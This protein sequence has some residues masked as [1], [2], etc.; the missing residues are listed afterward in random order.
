[1]SKVSWSDFDAVLFDLDGVITATASIHAAAWKAA[2]DEFLEARGGDHEPFDIET[3]YRAHV[4]GRPRYEGVAAFLESRGIDL[5]RGLPS[6]RPGH[7]TIC[8]LGNLKNDAFER[9][10]AERGADVYEGSIALLDH[11]D[12]IGMPYAVVSASKNAVPIL[13]SVGHLPRFRAV[14]DGLVAAELGL[15]GKP[16][17]DPFLEGARRVG[18]EPDRAVVVED[19]V[20]G[21]QAGQA[22]GFGLVIG[23]DRHDDPD[24]LL[25]AGADVVVDDLAALVPTG[26]PSF[27][28]GD[29][30][31]VLVRKGLPG[32]VGM[33]ETLFALANGNLGVRGSFSQGAPVHE[34]GALLNG[35]HETWPIRYPEHA[36]GFPTVGQTIVYLPDATGLALHWNGE[37]LDLADAAVTRSLDL[38]SG[39]STTQAVWNEV[40]AVW[41]RVVPIRE[42]NVFAM[43]L[44]VTAALPGDVEVRHAIVNVQ[45]LE[46]TETDE[47]DPRRARGFGRRVLI[48][49]TQLT[50]GP[51]AGLGYRTARTRLPLAVMSRVGGSLDLGSWE[52]GADRASVAM[53]GEAR[54]GESHRVEVVVRYERGEVALDG[55]AAV[56]GFA[57]VAADQV[58]DFA[59]LWDTSEISIEGDVDAQRVVNFALFQLH[60]ASAAVD[61]TGI[62]AKGLTGQ[63]YEGHHFWDSDVFVGPFLSATHP[64]AAE[65]VIRWRHALLPKAHQRAIEMSLDG[66]LF[67]WRT[68]SGEE[69]SAFFEAGTAQFHVAADV[70]YGLRNHVTMTGDDDLLFDVGVDIAVGVARMFSSLGFWRGD[71]FHIHGV[72]GPDEYTALVN[73][74]AYTNQMA[75][76]AL[77]FAADTVDRLREERPGQHA[78][79]VDDMGIDSGEVGEWRRIADAMTV[80]VDEELGVTAQDATFLTL[81]PWDWSTPRDKYPLLLNFHPLVIY[82]HQ[83]LKQA[84]VVMAHFLLPEDTRFERKVAD[85]DFYDPLTTGDSSLSP[86]IQSAVAARLGRDNLAWEYFKQ[87]AAIDL[88]DLAGNTADGIHLAAAAG[89]WL[90]VVKGFAGMELGT[91]GVVRTDPRLPASWR[92][93][94]IRMQVRGEPVEVS[95]GGS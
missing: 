6:D 70:V 43:D 52:V 22:G 55:L 16:E 92:S 62:P 2:F 85:F 8:A 94:T 12:V 23:V 30:P 78:T 33:D 72:T 31:W 13:E 28:L 83:M 19:A 10:L 82:K 14:V 95:L 18:V 41:R 67:P 38:R 65:A 75:R 36:Y 24:S 49:E 79:L 9:V 81:E 34:P 56:G 35:F 47:D 71:A 54:P 58:D 91:D 80:L 50:D 27:D 61:G 68:I 73:D 59:R 74:N 15:L 89:A 76:M 57:E 77:R 11:L 7:D 44:T 60:Q 93:L 88:A 64:R 29:D 42:G 48:P 32:S 87:A 69:A 53:I 17:P 3:D 51:V 45:D 63:A 84:D 90:A 39:V 20:S 21:V 26:W 37:L 25:E 46:H 1:V 66:V 5:P 4:D 40:T 86:A